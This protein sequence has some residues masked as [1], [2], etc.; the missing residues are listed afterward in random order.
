MSDAYIVRR[1]K[2]IQGGGGFDPN[3]AA[4]KVVTSTGCSVTVT[5]TG[6]SQTHKNSDGF[7]RSDDANVTEHFFAIPA[8]AF[9]TITVTA[10][11]VYGTNT[12][13]I[14]V[15]TAGKVYEV[16]CA[17]LNIIL[18]S[19]FGLKSGWGM[20]LKSGSYGSVIFD[21]YNLKYKIMSSSNGAA[22]ASLFYEVGG[23]EH[24][25]IDFSIYDNIKFTYTAY[26]ISYPY[27]HFRLV[28][29]DSQSY[30]DTQITTTSEKTTITLTPPDKLKN[31]Y[32]VIAYF[33]GAY[34]GGL[35]EVF[36]IIFT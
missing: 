22:R 35:V 24:E 31:P 5:G 1:G 2:I 12:K 11:N 20:H 30:S 28:G 21:Q 33:P 13:T 23:E 19:T 26:N 36:E 14:T 8:S 6:Y 3:G 15:D 16:L 10:T 25:D 17:G 34:S 32:Q 7:P 9:G 4:L 18:D 29:A 27:P